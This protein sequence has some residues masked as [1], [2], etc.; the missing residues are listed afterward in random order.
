MAGWRK[1][2]AGD[3][4][5]VELRQESISSHAVVLRAI[6]GMGAELMQEHRHAMAEHLRLLSTVDWSKAN[7]DWEGV[8]IVANS[9]VSNRQARAATKA[10]IKRHIGLELTEAEARA[11]SARA[12]ATAAA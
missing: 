12:P 9:V 8:C 5:A 1:V 11:L 7:R 6:G 3:L 4:K 2:K 10:Y